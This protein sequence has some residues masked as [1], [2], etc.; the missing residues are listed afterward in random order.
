MKIE[1]G[2]FEDLANLHPNTIVQKIWVDADENVI[3]PQLLYD[4]SKGGLID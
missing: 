2:S 4:E 3:K 1:K